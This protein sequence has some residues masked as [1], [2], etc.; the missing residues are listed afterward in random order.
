[1]DASEDALE[2]HR[3]PQETNKEQRAKAKGVCA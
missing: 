1:L 3:G 2:P